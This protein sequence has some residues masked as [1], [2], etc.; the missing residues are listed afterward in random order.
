MYFYSHPWSTTLRVLISPLFFWITVELMV[1]V[2]FLRLP[3]QLESFNEKPWEKIRG[4]GRWEASVKMSPFFQMATVFGNGSITSVDLCL[5]SSNP[6]S[7]SLMVFAAN[8][9]PRAAS[10][11]SDCFLNFYYLCNKLFAFNF[12]YLKTLSDFC[13]PVFTFTWPNCLFLRLFII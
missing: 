5:G 11:P 7:C 2:A 12:S 6:D 3:Y 1:E 8:A 10:M 4:G 13:S 9:T